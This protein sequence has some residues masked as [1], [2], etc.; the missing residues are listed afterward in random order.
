MMS[1]DHPIPCIF[2]VA[3]QHFSLYVFTGKYLNNYGE[4]GTDTALDYI[5]PGWTTW[6]TLQGN[7]SLLCFVLQSFKTRVYILSIAQKAGK[8]TAT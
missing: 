4:P 6:F 3:Q 7:R 2:N 1:T 5:P 8:M